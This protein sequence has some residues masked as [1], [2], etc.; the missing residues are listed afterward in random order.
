M[1]IKI[2]YGNSCFSSATFFCLSSNVMQGD[3][4][5]YELLITCTN[6]SKNLPLN[7][8]T[9]LNMSAVVSI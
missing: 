1:Y 8:I 9:L 4:T 3:K 7:V 6:T 2:A 5:K